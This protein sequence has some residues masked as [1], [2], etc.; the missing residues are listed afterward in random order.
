MT[1]LL[2]LSFGALFASADPV[3][4]NVLNAVVPYRNA[5]AILG[6]V[7]AFGLVTAAALAATYTARRPPL[8][9]TLAPAPAA[10]LRRWEWAMPLAILDVLF[11]SFVAVELTVLFG[12]ADTCSPLPG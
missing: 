6:R 8:F 5:P 7:V 9:D 3:Y 10:R 1:L 2:L 4:A 12:G 11:A